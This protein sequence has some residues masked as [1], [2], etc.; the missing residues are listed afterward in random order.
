[1]RR[2]IELSRLCRG[3]DSRKSVSSLCR[4]VQGKEEGRGGI[5]LYVQVRPVLT[6]L[7]K[8]CCM[9]WNPSQFL[10]MDEMDVPFRDCMLLR[11]V[12]PTRRQVMGSFSMPCVTSQDMCSTSPSN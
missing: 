4:Q 10:S 1:M 2:R 9:N 11:N 3:I 5:Q 12:S 7:Q 6:E 8:Q